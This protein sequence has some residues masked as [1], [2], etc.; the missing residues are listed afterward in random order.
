MLRHG[1]LKHK[2]NLGKPP[3]PPTPSP[4]PP[5]LP[6]FD[7]I[8][9]TTY[10]VPY[11][12]HT[13]ALMN[14]EHLDASIFD[15]NSCSATL[16]PALYAPQPV[17]DATLLNS[18]FLDHQPFYNIPY[19]HELLL[20]NGFRDTLIKAAQAM[21]QPLKTPSNFSLNCYVSLFIEK[22]LPHCPF[23]P[24]CFNIEMANP[25]LLISMASIGAL[26]GV[27][28]TTALMLHTV[29]KNLEES[30][31]SFIGCE[32]YPLWAVQSLYLNSVFSQTN[33]IY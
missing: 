10:P 20:Q 16:D 4:P 28:K 22:F 23:L 30:L 12:F 18:L 24:P 1:R 21:S 14:P 2:T 3:P 8:T 32:N 29:G 9:S 13:L 33:H 19:T 26:Y 15:T 7:P 11:R 17:P 27:E 31:R 25:L 5:P 6:K